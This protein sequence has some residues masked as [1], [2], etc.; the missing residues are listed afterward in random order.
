MERKVGVV[1][2]S[3]KRGFCIL[4]VGPESSLERYYLHVSKIRSGTATPVAGQTVYFDVNDSQIREG[5][6]PVALRADVIVEPG[7]A[8]SL[9]ANENGGAQ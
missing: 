6:L 8:T 1:Q 7:N 3:S 4:R 9:P 2:V 5:Q